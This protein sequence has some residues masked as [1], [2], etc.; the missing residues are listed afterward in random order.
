AVS[1]H[2]ALAR[3]ATSGV[4]E[5]YGKK[6]EVQGASWMDHEFFTQQLESNQI[7]WDWLSLQLQDRTELMLF[8]I[9]QKDGSIDPHSAGT[10]VDAAG[11]T[12]HLRS[13]DFKM[14]PDRKSTRLNSSH[15][16][17]S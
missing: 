6:C 13:N 7:G 1:H 9:R 15:G 3:L 14:E 2:I 10:Y 11:K 12:A 17:I 4:I 16:S 5:L 8:H